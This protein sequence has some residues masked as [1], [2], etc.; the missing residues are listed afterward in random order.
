MCVVFSLQEYIHTASG[1]RVRRQTLKDNNESS[2]RGQCHRPSRAPRPGTST[3]CITTH[4]ASSSRPRRLAARNA[5]NLFSSMNSNEEAENN[6]PVVAASSPPPAHEDGPQALDSENRLGICVTTEEPAPPEQ[7]AN[8]AEV[9][10][11][12]L[13]WGREKRMV[14]EEEVTISKREMVENAGECRRPRSHRR[15]VLK[16]RNG[17]PPRAAADGFRLEEA[18]VPEEQTAEATSVPPELGSLPLKEANSLV[19]L[20]LASQRIVRKLVVKPPSRPMDPGIQKDKLALSRETWTNNGKAILSDSDE[21]FPTAYVDMSHDEKL[22]QEWKKAKVGKFSNGYPNDRSTHHGSGSNSLQAVQNC[23]ETCSMVQKLDRMCNSDGAQHK[24]TCTLAAAASP[25]KSCAHNGDVLV[26]EN[27]HENNLGQ[28]VNKELDFIETQN[29]PEDGK[30]KSEKCVENKGLEASHFAELPTWSMGN[31]RTLGRPQYSKFVVCDV[32]DDLLQTAT[33]AEAGIGET[34]EGEAQSHQQEDEQDHLCDGQNKN[35]D[36]KKASSEYTDDGTADTGCQ[37]NKNSQ[38]MDVH[39]RNNILEES[40]VHV[41]ASTEELLQAKDSDTEQELS[42]KSLLPNSDEEQVDV[43]E[44]HESCL[45]LQERAPTLHVTRS[46]VI[47][48]EPSSS[49]IRRHQP[50]RLIAEWEAMGDE[51]DHGDDQ[52]SSFLYTQL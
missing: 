28:Q 1:R 41:A 32:E 49:R 10:Q 23:D 17:G 36:L 15:L 45:V 27:G 44:H 3:A 8:P 13:E 7:E 34:L 33:D 48:D 39:N 25:L 5:L 19:A 24:R 30:S 35:M 52:V 12:E 22:K 26:K 37:A 2:E 51:P 50:T 4:Q 18:E 21:G 46:R 6:N 31:R 40:V 20:Q 11:H 47:V 9:V 16:L 43:E 38:D 14:E 42:V 29:H